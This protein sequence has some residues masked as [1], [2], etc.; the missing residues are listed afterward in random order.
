MVE[1]EA[2]TIGADLNSHIPEEQLLK[3]ADTKRPVY[4]TANKEDSTVPF[5]STKKYVEL[6]KK[7][8]DKYDLKGFWEQ[9]KTCGGD[10]HCFGHLIYTDE[11]ENKLK[12]FWGDVFWETDDDTSNDEDAETKLFEMGRWSFRATRSNIPS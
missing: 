5:S 7:N 12:K 2:M 1:E 9:D 8:G 4:V 11:Y 6:F 3:G 10:G